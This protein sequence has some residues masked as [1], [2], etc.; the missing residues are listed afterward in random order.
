MLGRPGS[1]KSAIYR[2]LE[3]RLREEGLAQEVIRID[4]FPVLQ[5]LLDEDVEFKRHYRKEGGFVVTDFTILDDVLKEINRKLHELERPGKIIFV[6]FA[7]DKYTRALENFDRE[8]LGRSL[9]LYIYCPFEVCV[10][11]NVRRFR[12]AGSK[13]VDDHIAP[14]DIMKRYYKY[15]DYGEFYL[16]SEDELKKR[17]PASIVV[18]R[19]DVGGIDRLKLELEKAIEMFKI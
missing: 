6:E 4:D 5:K 3:R 19:N 2:T 15:D 10:E 14:T 7:R 12:E 9:I 16:K 1:G 13:S 18:V 17:A 11:R 8:V